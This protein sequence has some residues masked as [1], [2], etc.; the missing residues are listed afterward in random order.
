MKVK[1]QLIVAVTGIIIIAAIGISVIAI[2]SIQDVY[3]LYSDSSNILYAQIVSNRLLLKTVIGLLTVVILISAITI[4]FGLY[5][6]RRI[7]NPYLRIIE[8]FS[9]LASN[10]FKLRSTPELS[11]AEQTLLQSYVSTLQ[12]D[13]L[14]LKELEKVESFKEGASMLLHEL[15]N[16]LTP[17]KLSIETLLCQYNGEN[18]T[19]N[20]LHLSLL[21]VESILETFRTLVSIEFKE[22]K[23]LQFNSFFDDFLSLRDGSM[24]KIESNYDET[25]TIFSE[26]T[27][28]RQILHN[29]I[30]NGLD[31]GKDAFKISIKQSETDLVIE[32]I[33]PE[34][35][36]PNS[37]NPF[38]IKSS[39]K[40]NNRGYGLYICKKISDYLE[41]P[42]HL[43]SRENPVIF[44]IEVPLY[45]SNTNT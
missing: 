43:T 29:L 9:Q 38:K 2:T 23:P 8:E 42:L 13:V 19:I 11:E 39:T 40:G 3:K 1:H 44:T 10:R 28:F 36:I 41:H 27:L 24:F 26:P 20:R 21:E 25:C 6:V 45:D 15:K 34:A 4:P 18:K 31:H 12:E 14:R 22:K 17:L 37:I 30:N 35:S 32:C 5:Y 33:T 16:P 7:T